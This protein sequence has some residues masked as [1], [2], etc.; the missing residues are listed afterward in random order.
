MPFV[1]SIGTIIGPSIGGYFANPADNFPD[2]FSAHGIFAEYPYL[3]PNLICAALMLGSIVTGFF[4]LEETHPDMQ[5]WSTASDLANT[6]AETPLIPAQAGT[7]TAAANLAQEAS[8]GTF[9][10]VKADQ[11]QEWAIHP[12]SRRAS[13]SSGDSQKVFNKRV[14]MLVVA[15]GLYT[16]HSSSYD[17]LLPIFF[18]D[19]RPDGFLHSASETITSGLGLSI[20]QVGVIM[21]VNGLIALF[22][23]AVIF[24]L[25]AAWL[26]I[27][28]VFLLV[29]ILHPTAY[30]LMPYLAILPE[31]LLYP[32]IY[33]C[34]TIR[35]I[36]SILAYPVLL[37]LL[38][39]AAP[40]PSSLGKINGLAASTGA[41]CRT[42]ASPI[43]GLLYT[44]GI[45]LHFTPL[46]WWASAFI[47]ILGAIQVFFI[48]PR[49]GP[50]L[51]HVTSRA[52]CRF[53]PVD[54]RKDVVHVHVPDETDSGYEST[55]EERQSLLEV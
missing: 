31:S 6:E 22:V 17:T 47:A 1:W 2:T 24:P 50:E 42:I 41:A 23:Q 52:P 35:N 40:S 3:L 9:N 54:Q 16:W 33:A 36:F 45:E 38:K 12:A 32:G 51:H 7:T 14:I 11:E 55:N 27:W 8:Y 21:S 44:V 25:M 4:L 29:T 10:R 30:I 19:E 5:P 13:V 39:E 28:K 18:Q 34:L 26:G 46:A 48:R 37:I 49:Q 53:L 15:L 43:S 20:Q